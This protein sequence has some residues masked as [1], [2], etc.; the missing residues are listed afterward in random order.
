MRTTCVVWLVLLTGGCTLIPRSDPFSNG[1][2]AVRLV[3]AVDSA[4]SGERIQIAI[5][6]T[7]TSTHQ[8]RLPNPDFFTVV[9]DFGDGGGGWFVCRM[10]AVPKPLVL[11]PGKTF[12]VAQECTMPE[13]RS[14]QT[15][16]FYLQELPTVRAKVRIT[17]PLRRSARGTAF[18]TPGLTARYQRR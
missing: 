12:R 13:A 15:V 9:P 8:L 17:E 6:V 4:R 18:P 7:N 10:G 16:Q 11:A 3:P 2:A 14:G 5:E 1:D